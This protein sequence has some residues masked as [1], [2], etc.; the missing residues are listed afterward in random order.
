MLRRNNGYIADEA[1]TTFVVT[2]RTPFDA[3]LFACE[4]QHAMLQAQWDPVLDQYQATERITS[5]DTGKVIFCG[6]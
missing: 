6:M 5:A 2:F 1:H 4:L 3:V